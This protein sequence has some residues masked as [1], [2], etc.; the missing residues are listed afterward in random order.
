[1]KARN[2][3]GALAVAILLALPLVIPSVGRIETWKIV[4]GL[5]GLLLFVSA[6]LSS[7]I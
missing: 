1:M 7:R 5:A 6:G 2:F 3:A 4:L